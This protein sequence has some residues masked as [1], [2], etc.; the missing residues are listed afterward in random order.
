MANTI[1]T[2][3]LRTIALIALTLLFAVSGAPADAATDVKTRIFV[4][5]QL[6][7]E[8]DAS[9]YTYSQ[10]LSPGC[11]AIRVVITSERQRSVQTARPCPK[12]PSELVVKVRNGVPSFKISAVT[13]SSS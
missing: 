8:S 9:S 7:K 3:K 5:G 2:W 11:H 1:S 6:V 4:D 10:S 13:S 12:K